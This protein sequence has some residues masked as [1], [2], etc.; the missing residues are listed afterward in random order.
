[1]IDYN[2]DHYVTP[3]VSGLRSDHFR[4]ATDRRLPLWFVAAVVVIGIVSAAFSKWW[5]GA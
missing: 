3:R 5:W 4:R 2:P 1:M